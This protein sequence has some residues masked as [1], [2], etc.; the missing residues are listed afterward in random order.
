MSM[1]E[2]LEAMLEKG[3]DSPLL[4]LSLGNAYLDGG[5]PGAAVAHLVEAVRQKPDY[6]AAWKS[7]GKALIE[8]GRVADAELAY[9]RGIEVAEANGDKQAAKEMAVFLKRLRR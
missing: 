8:A 3:Q 7:Y 4:R 2:N 6:S 1:I 9:A 5:E